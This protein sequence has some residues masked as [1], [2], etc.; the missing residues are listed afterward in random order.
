LAR[1]DLCE[2]GV[3]DTEF[4]AQQ[5]DLRLKATVLRSETDTGDAIRQ[6]FSEEPE[7]FASR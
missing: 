3:L 2:A 7:A 5:G 6:Q 4:L 1:R